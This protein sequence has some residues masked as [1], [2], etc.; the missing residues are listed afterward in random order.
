M[1]AVDTEHLMRVAHR[2]DDEAAAIRRRAAR[3]GDAASAAAW[4]G[5]AAD[6]FRACVAG[7]SSSLRHAAGRLESAADA[8]RTHARIVRRV[9]EVAHAAERAGHA[10]T[11][12]ARDVA[13]AVTHI[14]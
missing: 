1:A 11:D 5:R 2:L 13:R 10:V 14:L 4:R 9:E 6:A 7:Q 3:L 12:G 8:L